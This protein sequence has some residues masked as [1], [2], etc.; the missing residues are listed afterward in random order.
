M[1][2]ATSR[3]PLPHCRRAVSLISLIDRNWW[4]SVRLIQM[5]Y[6]DLRFFGLII[7]SVLAAGLL[8]A[9]LVGGEVA[10]PRVAQLQSHHAQEK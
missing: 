10:G 6:G 8:I 5:S 3:E 4:L 7:G 2:A 1:T 9:L